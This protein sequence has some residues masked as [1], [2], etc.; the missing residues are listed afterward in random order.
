MNYIKLS[1]I[2]VI[3]SVLTLGF[4]K[5][6]EPQIG[7]NI[8]NIA[9]ELNFKNPDGKMISLSSLRGNI[10]LIDFWA[11][12]CGPC[13]RENPNLVGAYNKYKKAKFKEAKGF[14]VY[15]IS[16]DKNMN[17]WKNA[18]V[19]DKLEWPSHVSDLGGWASQPGRIY[20]IRS[21][22]TGYLIDHNGIII[23]KNVRGMLLHQAIDAHVKS[24]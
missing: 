2:A 14:E 18:I 7:L 24:L 1:L 5:K 8:G 19:Q 23:A 3:V 17:S 21:I 10:V 12:W 13:R 22:P 20:G 11:S 6:Q 15:S 16:L 4:S 9:P